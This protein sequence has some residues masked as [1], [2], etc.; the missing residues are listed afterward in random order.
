MKTLQCIQGQG[1][2]VFRVGG[3]TQVCVTE[4]EDAAVGAVHHRL[5][6]LGHA[7]RA[8]LGLSEHTT[9]HRQPMV[10]EN[11]PH[12]TVCPLKWSVDWSD[13]STMP[14]LTKCELLI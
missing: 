4:A 1:W 13:L 5:D 12:V 2:C 9:E 7:P 6:D 14:S 11:P 10:R 3:G 8:H